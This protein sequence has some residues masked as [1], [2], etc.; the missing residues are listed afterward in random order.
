MAI[1]NPYQLDET[2]TLGI[3]SALGR[4]NVGIAQYEDFIQTDAAI[5]PGNSGG[6]LLNVRGEVVGVNTA[7]YS[8]ARS[9][10]NM[11]I[12]FAIPINT[13]RDL[14]PQLR[15]GKVTRGVIGVEIQNVPL[16]ALAEF[17]LKE[18]RGALVS[19]VRAGG[20]A[21][22]AGL[23]PGDIILEFNGKPVHRRDELT[24]IVTATKPGSTVP[25]KILR[26]KREMSLN[27]TVDELDLENENTVRAARR[28]NPDAD[29]DIQETA[30]FGL[31]LGTLTS[32]MARRLRV[33]PGTEGVLVQDVEPAGPA[34][35]AG[36]GR[37]DII[38]QVNRR[39][40]GTVQ[41]VQRALSAVPSGGTAS[42]LVLSNGQQRF[43]VM[44]KE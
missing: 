15:A 44:R 20:P 30:G 40:V 36:V 25:V 18:R 12:G 35:R 23:E 11:G 41:E 26:D 38:L 3:V 2:V 9:Q 43:V 17:G 7:I 22:K 8:D 19:T 10:G 4:A 34:Q 1:G 6:P 13:V 24:P 42:L 5:N 37:G 31:S 16:N 39:P 28:N 32:D 21:A 14:L 33:P 29:P 27:V